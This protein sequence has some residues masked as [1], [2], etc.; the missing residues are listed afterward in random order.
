MEAKRKEKPPPRG[1]GEER[2]DH[3]DSLILLV[4]DRAGL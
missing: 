4:N 1:D 2:F 3:Q